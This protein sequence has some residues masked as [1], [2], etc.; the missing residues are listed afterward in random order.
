MQVRGTGEFDGHL[1]DINILVEK[2]RH[3]ATCSTAKT[4]QHPGHRMVLILSSHAIVDGVSSRVDLRDFK[5]HLCRFQFPSSLLNL[6]TLVLRVHASATRPGKRDVLVEKMRLLA[7]RSTAK[8]EQ[9]PGHRMVL[10]LSSHAIVDGVSSRIDLRDFK[11]HLCR[12][13]FPSSLLNLWTLV[14]RVHASATR[15]GKR[16]VLVKKMRLLA[17]HSAAEVENHSGHGVVTLDTYPVHQ[18]VVSQRYFG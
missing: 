4:E 1:A 12:F 2:M 8:T 14:L 6:W 13:Q 7:T 17:T 5:A 3:L 9:H 16:D 15:P 11:A 18:V 10:I